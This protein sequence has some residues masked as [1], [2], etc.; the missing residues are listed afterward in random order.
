MSGSLFFRWDNWDKWDKPAETR[1]GIGFPLSHLSGT[2]R[3][4]TGT[5][6]DTL[7][8]LGGKT[9]SRR[10]GSSAL[11]LSHSGA[12]EGGQVPGIAAP[13]A[14]KSVPLDPVP[15]SSVA[16]RGSRP[17]LTLSMYVVQVVLL[18]TYLK[19]SYDPTLIKKN[20]FF[21]LG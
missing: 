8:H 3:F 13:G 11:A 9:L 17:A 19:C 2:S 7:S 16:Q 20:T 5:G 10:P 18:L 12:A 21:S 1:M 4:L 15:L 6:W 14:G